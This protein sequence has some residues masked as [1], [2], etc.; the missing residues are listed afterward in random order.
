MPI[1]N[2]T[3]PL[4]SF[5][6]SSDDSKLDAA[7]QEAAANASAKIPIVYSPRFHDFKKMGRVPFTGWAF[8]P[9]YP[10]PVEQK[11]GGNPYNGDIKISG[12]GTWLKFGTG[13]THGVKCSGVFAGNGK[14]T[15]ADTDSGGVCWTSVFPYDACFTE[16]V[17]VLGNT[18]KFLY[19]MT[20]MFRGHCNIN[21]ARGVSV[22]VGGS[23]GKLFVGDRS[24]IDG[25][26]GVVGSATPHLWLD[27]AAKTN[28]GDPYITSE[29]NWY[30]LRVSG[31][32]DRFGVTITGANL[33]GR[34]APQPS[35]H[36]VIL[37][38][39]GLVTYRD[40]V[41]NYS[42]AELMKITGGKA[43]VLGLMGELA[44][45]RE[46][47]APIITTSGSGKLRIRDVDIIGMSRLPIVKGNGINADDSVQVLP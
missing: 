17:H 16:F 30:A 21:N 4:D 10:M 43:R 12:D 7:W 14:N 3:I 25:R 9:Q 40:L 22:R 8:G 36:P 39:G 1:V 41:A 45:D 6:G 15:F 18:K 23:D 38:E 29:E 35:K 47:T 26:V 37:H 34:H 42:L 28:V 5:S 11:R 44:K 2:G 24:N 13:E 33:E 27:G 31:G 19:T 32:S 46:E 20:T